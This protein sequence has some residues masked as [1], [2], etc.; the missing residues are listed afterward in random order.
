M[1]AK[2]III[3][4]NFFSMANNSDG[5]PDESEAGKKEFDRYILTIGDEDEIPT[6]Q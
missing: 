1:K 3:V 4:N 2:K 6:L 5:K